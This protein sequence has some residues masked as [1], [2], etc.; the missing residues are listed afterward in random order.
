MRRIDRRSAAFGG[1][2]RHGCVVLCLEGRAP[3][4]TIFLF[5]EAL[6]GA[7]DGFLGGRQIPGR[8]HLGPGHAGRFDRLPRIAHFLDGRASAAG[9][10]CDTDENGDQAGHRRP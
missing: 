5:I 1:G 7:G 6:F 10:A 3:R 2:E 4:A 9:E 8:A